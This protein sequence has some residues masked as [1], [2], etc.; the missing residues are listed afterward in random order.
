MI[1]FLRTKRMSENESIRR[2]SEA[3]PM[4]KKGK[5]RSG[6]TRTEEVRE[7]VKK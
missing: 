1:L 6:S 5:G 2:I 4:K 3:R 7:T